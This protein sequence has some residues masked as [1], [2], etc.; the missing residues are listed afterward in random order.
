MANCKY[1]NKTSN[2]YVT[3]NYYCVRA[4]IGFSDTTTKAEYTIS[5]DFKQKKL[6]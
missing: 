1:D 3:G 4:G 5:Y 2:T 6:K